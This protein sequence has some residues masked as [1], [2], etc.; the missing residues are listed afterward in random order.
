MSLFSFMKDVGE[1]LLTPA[2][3]AA[4]ASA[5]PAAGAQQAQDVANGETI[6]KYISSLGLNV[7]GLNVTYD[8]ASYTA[9]GG[10]NES[11]QGTLGKR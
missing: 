7:S 5:A 10:S 11:E 4:A 2:H 8:S 6:K 1:K 9:H 3:G